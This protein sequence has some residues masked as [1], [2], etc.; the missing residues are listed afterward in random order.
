MREIL[1]GFAS[2]SIPTLGGGG[3]Q[4]HSVANSKELS[5]HVLPSCQLAHRM[6]EFGTSFHKL[7][8]STQ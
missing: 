6:R 7:A 2:A 4:G 1:S 3:K 8:G 5:E